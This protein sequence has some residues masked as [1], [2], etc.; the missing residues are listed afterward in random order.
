[1]VSYWKHGEAQKARVF[2]AHDG[3]TKMEIFGE[4]YPF[5]GYPRGHLLFG[6]LSPLKHWIKNKIF[7]DAW[8]ALE[9][10]VERQEVIRRMKLAWSEDICPLIEKAKVDM[11]PE[12]KMSVPVRELYRAL[13]VI[14]E[15]HDVQ[16]FKECVTY[17]FQEDDAYRF[18]FQWLVAYWNPSSVFNLFKKDFAKDFELAMS[19]LEHAEVI[20]DM[21]ERIRLWKRGFMLMLEDKEMKQIFDELCREVDWNKVKLTSADR[22]YMRA[23]YFKVDYDRGV[24]Y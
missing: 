5:P 8:Y 1:M 14:Q 16:K 24:E 20:G 6:S 18:R 3:S 10:S 23:K 22:Y 7:N 4:K 9:S 17:I 2:T 12:E 21:K 19:M 13:S 11:V 15:R